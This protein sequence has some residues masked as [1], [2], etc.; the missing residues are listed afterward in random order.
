MA[1]MLTKHAWFFFFFSGKKLHWICLTQW[2]LFQNK[3]EVDLFFLLLWSLR[4]IN[5]FVYA[6]TASA[7]Y[8]SAV[9][10]CILPTLYCEETSVLLLCIWLEIFCLR[11]EKFSRVSEKL[12]M[13]VCFLFHHSTWLQ[14]WTFYLAECDEVGTALWSHVVVVVQ[15]PLPWGDPWLDPGGQSCGGGVWHYIV[16]WR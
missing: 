6:A 4:G 12:Q 16:T 3:S 11:N 9:R 10:K 13:Y 5:L 8:E 1:F 2:T 14:L 7:C 15:D